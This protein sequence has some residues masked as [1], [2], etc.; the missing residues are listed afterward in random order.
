MRHYIAKFNS[1]GNMG[2]QEIYIFAKNIEQAQDK[3]FEYLK[4]TSLYA[5]M[6]QLSVRIREIDGA[7]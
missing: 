7:V 6:W 5:H 2:E 3:F 4:N 1:E